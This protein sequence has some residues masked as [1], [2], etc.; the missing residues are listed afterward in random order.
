MQTSVC[1]G[2]EKR[3]YSKPGHFLRKGGMSDW[4]HEASGTG[5]THRR[6]WM[7]HTIQTQA[8]NSMEWRAF[9]FQMLYI[10]AV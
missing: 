4:T 5:Q 3:T 9:Y 8:R 10:Y 7:S 2:S 6:K 1:S